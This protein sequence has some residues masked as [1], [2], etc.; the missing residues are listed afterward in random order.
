MKLKMLDALVLIL[1]YF[2]KK[3]MSI[4][5]VKGGKVDNVIRW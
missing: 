5:L 1:L 2:M 3:K 4:F